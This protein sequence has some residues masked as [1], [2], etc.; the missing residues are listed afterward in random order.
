MKGFW[1]VDGELLLLVKSRGFSSDIWLTIV[2]VGFVFKWREVIVVIVWWGES[3]NKMK[4]PIQQATE[5][6]SKARTL[7]QATD[8]RKW[9]HDYP[10]LSN[11]RR[12][13]VSLSCHAY[14]Y[15]IHLHFNKILRSMV[16]SEFNKDS[17][18]YFNLAQTTQI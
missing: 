12:R 3:D 8:N 6:L 7:D 4:Q 14:D 1:I 16:N 17:F 13:K 2:C 10:L 11:R 15:Q 5:T 9:L 18:K